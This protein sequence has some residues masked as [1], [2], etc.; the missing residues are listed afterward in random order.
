MVQM[1]RELSRFYETFTVVQAVVSATDESGDVVDRAFTTYR[2]S[3][4]PFLR[5][6]LDAEK[7]N[8]RK[9]LDE[10]VSRGALTVRAVAATEDVRQQLRRVGTDVLTKPPVQWRKRRRH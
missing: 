5:G 10:E 6:Q 7:K 1:R 2:D 9:M 3:L 8:V 4:M